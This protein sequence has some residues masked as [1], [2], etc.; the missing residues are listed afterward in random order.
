MNIEEFIWTTNQAKTLSD[1]FS[2]Y[3]KAMSERG[4]DRII[5]SLITEHADIDEKA[6]LGYFKNYPEHWHRHY[7][8]NGYGEIDPVIVHGVKYQQ[9]FIW[10][11]ISGRY[12]LTIAQ[13]AIL[14][15]GQESGLLDG[16]SIP[17]RDR[18]QAIA[19]VGAASSCGNIHLD[20]HTLSVANVLSYQFYNRFLSLAAAKKKIPPLEFSSREIE[21]LKWISKGLTKEQVAEKMKLSRHTIDYHV[22]NILIKTDSPN[23]T[24]AAVKSIQKNVIFL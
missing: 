14:N 10:N 7:L 8:Q 2:I 12:D 13:Q 16:I 20:E 18:F 11:E 3:E 21:V 5:F 23:L 9:P 24:A 1:L 19:G 4:F 22:R 6:R 15:E 17:L